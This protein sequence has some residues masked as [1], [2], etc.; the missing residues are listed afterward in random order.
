MAFCPAQ[1][2]KGMVGGKLV[3]LAGL[4]KRRAAER[5]IY[6]EGIYCMHDG[7]CIDSKDMPDFTDVQADFSTTAKG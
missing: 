6:E 1:P 7:D 5:K 3:P 4:T 2:D